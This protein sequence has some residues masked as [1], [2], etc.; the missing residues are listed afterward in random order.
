MLHW[1]SL[2]LQTLRTLFDQIYYINRTCTLWVPAFRL[3]DSRY[4]RS[5][6]ITISVK[7]L[8][9]VEPWQLAKARVGRSNRLPAQTGP[10]SQQALTSDILLGFAL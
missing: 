5:P 9:F 2:S 3:S 1:F 8:I 6:K 4:D 10:Q 7:R